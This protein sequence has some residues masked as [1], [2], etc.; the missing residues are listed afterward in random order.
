MQYLN[1][2]NLWMAK[3]QFV[4]QFSKAENFSQ[5]YEESVHQ[6]REEA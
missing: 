2:F 4:I 6:K 3:S 5:Q 1:A